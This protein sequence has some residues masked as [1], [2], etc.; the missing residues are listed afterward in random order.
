MNDDRIADQV[1]GML[2]TQTMEPIDYMERET[3]RTLGLLMAEYAASHERVY[4]LLTLLIGGAG[5][6]GSYALT[7]LAAPAMQWAPLL[8]L[9]VWW[10]GIAAYL[11]ARGVQSHRLGVGGTP[12]VLCGSFVQKG[13]DFGTERQQENQLAL[14]NTRLAELTTHQERIMAYGRACSAR[15]HAMDKAYWA[16]AASPLP[17]LTVLVIVCW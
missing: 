9:A 14:T 2:Q 17:A 5:A 15:A 8:A 11:M 12:N 7:R 10:F 13:G 1:L 6:L 16:A 4:K 3:T